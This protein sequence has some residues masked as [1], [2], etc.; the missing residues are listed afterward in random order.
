[1]F[2]AS[3]CFLV[4]LFISGKEEINKSEVADVTSSGLKL[5]SIDYICRTNQIAIL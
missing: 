5:G 2:K 1:M 3:R 4:K